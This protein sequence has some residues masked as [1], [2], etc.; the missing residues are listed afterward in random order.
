MSRRS[1]RFRYVLGVLVLGV[2]T[3]EVGTRVLV[4]PKGERSMYREMS[5]D[6][7]QLR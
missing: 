6:F 1:R 7:E 5:Q 4:G 3:L 2:L